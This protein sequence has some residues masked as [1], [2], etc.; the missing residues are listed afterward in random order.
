MPYLLVA[1]AVAAVALVVVGRWEQR[2]DAR[3]QVHGMAG[4]AALVGPLGRHDLSGYRIFPAMDCLTY[5]RGSNAL[6]LELC[7]DPAGRIIEA[8]DRRRAARRIFSLR[9]DPTASTLR[10]DRSL[11]DR[12]LRRMGAIS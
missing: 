5:R 1:A 3:R 10:V 11:V 8:I 7:F 9:F 4:I 12:L 2:H 6:A